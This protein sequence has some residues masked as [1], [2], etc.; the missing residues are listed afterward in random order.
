MSRWIV[1]LAFWAT[2]CS[3]TLGSSH[4]WGIAVTEEMSQLLDGA[5]MPSAIYSTADD[6]TLIS[7][8]RNDPARQRL[9]D[10][11]AASSDFKFREFPRSPSYNR[12][13]WGDRGVVTLR[14]R[15]HDYLEIVVETEKEP[16]ILRL[17]RP[18]HGDK[19][20]QVVVL[21]D[22]D[23][24]REYWK[25]V[26]M[27]LVANTPEITR[28]WSAFETSLRGMTTTVDLPIWSNRAPGSNTIPM[29]IFML[30]YSL[31]PELSRH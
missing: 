4:S 3:T 11:Y 20:A 17:I 13:N 12:G 24:K 7:G 15:R 26:D 1:A 29:V 21:R 5:E 6:L 8:K 28:A 9:L 14:R 22:Y 19:H 18:T 30:P 10:A 23:R 16:Q 25:Q 31:H 2:G 27:G